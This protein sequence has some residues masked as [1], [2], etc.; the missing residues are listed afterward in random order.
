MPVRTGASP[1]RSGSPPDVT[2]ATS[3]PASAAAARSTRLSLPLIGLSRIF[4]AVSP[5]S[6]IVAICGRH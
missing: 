3:T 6:S 4:P 5:D 1:A 2:R